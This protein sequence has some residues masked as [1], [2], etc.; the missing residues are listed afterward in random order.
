MRFWV[1]AAAIGVMTAC[2]I[3][4]LLAIAVLAAR[5]LLG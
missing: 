1:H 2:A 3:A 5:L 4:V